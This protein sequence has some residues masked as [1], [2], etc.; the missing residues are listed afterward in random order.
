MKIVILLL[1]FYLLI[2]CKAQTFNNIQTD[3]PQKTGVD[4]TIHKC[5]SEIFNDNPRFGLSIGIIKNDLEF[6]YNY[7]SID[8]DISILPTSTTIYE[9]GSITKT[10]TGI[11]LA[12]AV[13][14]NK[15]KLDDDI[16]IYLNEDYKNLEYNGIPIR[17]INLANHTAGLPEDIYADTLYKMKN[18]TM[19]DIINVYKGDS[20]SIFL[21]GLHNV[22]LESQPGIKIQYSNTGIIILGN[23]LENL[24][25]I[26]YPKLLEKYITNPLRMTNTNIVFFES[27]TANYTKGYDKVGNIMPHITFQIA[28][29]AGGLKSTIYDMAQYV[30]ANLKETN[31]AIKLSH[32]LTTDI[33]GNGFGL[34]WQIRRSIFGYSQLWHD[35]GEPGFSSYCMIIPSKNIGIICLMN[36]RG[37]Q[38]QLCNLSEKILLSFQ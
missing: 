14:D 7:G 37:R 21:K 27:D 24:Y 28:G 1:A 3:N 8:K 20:G 38:S 4:S 36:Q 34:G 17:I 25:G 33:K 30:K 19:F 2:P 31:Y 26:S 32:K 29:A 22:K 6:F 5:V 18:P 23:I 11:L 15:I 10:F 13:L 9:I 12:Q 16:R 35:G